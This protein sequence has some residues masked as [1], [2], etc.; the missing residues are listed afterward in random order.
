MEFEAFLREAAPLLGLQWRVF[1]RRGTKR[2]IER[3]IIEAGESDLGGYLRK[4]KEDPEEQRHLSQ[5]LTVTIS[6]FFRDRAVFEMIETTVIPSLLEKRGEK[7]VRIWSIGCASGEEPYTLSLLWKE[8][9]VE[10]WPHLRFAVKAT[11]MGEG[12]LQRAKEGRYKRSSLAEVPNDILEKYFKREG[13]SY[14]LDKAIR[15]SVEFSRHDVIRE[16]PFSG[17]DM[18]LCRNLAF[19][20]FSKECQADVLQKIASSLKEGGYLVIGRDES[21]PLTYPT[22]FTPVFQEKKIYQKFA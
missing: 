20:Y 6:R 22:L 14:I 1:Q 4:V 5:I 9:F 13:D 2:R 18:V 16:G 12:L 3:R 21:V 17:M 15:E 11:D 7:G 8:K 19:T 10:R